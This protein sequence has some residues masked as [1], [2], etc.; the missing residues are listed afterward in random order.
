MKNKTVKQIGL[1]SA[2]ALTLTLGVCTLNAEAESTEAETAQETEAE[3]DGSTDGVSKEDILSFF[4]SLKT[5]SADDLNTYESSYDD[6]VAYLV[7]E[8]VIAE[9]AE[10]VDILTTEGYVTDNT[11]GSYP[12][13]AFADIANDYDG[14]YLLWWNLAGESETLDVYSAL[15][16][17]GVVV[18]MGGAVVFENVSAVSGCYAIGF[19]ADVDE[20]TA[21]TATAAFQSIDATVNSLDY[22][23]SATQLMTTL[24]KTGLIEAADIAANVDL[25]SVY[26]Y[27]TTAADWVGYDVSESGYGD[28]YDTTAYCALA[29]EAY[30]VGNICIYYYDTLNGF[31]GNNLSA[32]YEELNAEGTITPYCRL[33]MDGDWQAYT[34]EGE[35]YAED[36]EVLTITV[37]DFYGRFA[38][39]VNE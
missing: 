27:P 31:Y 26:S 6:I 32:V 39:V 16:T 30:Q 17:N 7:E 36:G 21:A 25:N 9:D 38:I 18:V 8:G 13:Y 10:P 23:T 12:T 20:E 15:Q 14:V 35:E 33:T 5:T 4:D 22:M 28:P 11:G 29:S 3:T 24:L 2:L 1:L 34:C 19:S 37:D